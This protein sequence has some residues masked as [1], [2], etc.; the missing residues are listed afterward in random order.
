VSLVAS[1][2]RRTRVAAP[3]VSLFA[4]EPRRAA[5]H[6]SVPGRGA[7][8]RS[9]AGTRTEPA[10]RDRAVVPPAGVRPRGRSPRLARGPVPPRIHPPGVE[11]REGAATARDACVT[12]PAPPRPSPTDD[13][14]LLGRCS[15]GDPGRGGASTLRGLDVAGAARR[16][17][18]RARPFSRPKSRTGGEPSDH[19]PPPPPL[20]GG[21]GCREGLK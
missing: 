19:P 5:R 1:N 9:E 6:S 8:L 13:D 20:G 14:A 11:M 10:R 16:Q 15:L 17:T 12:S 3:R 2:C 21:I 18:A 7:A 4:A